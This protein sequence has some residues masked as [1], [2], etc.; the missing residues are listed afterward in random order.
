[1]AHLLK[2]HDKTNK[3]ITSD[4]WIF[5]GA[6]NGGPVGN[7]N[8]QH[9]DYRDFVIDTFKRNLN[10]FAKPVAIHPIEVFSDDFFKLWDNDEVVSDIMRVDIQ[11]GGNISFAYIDGN[12]TYEYAKRDFQNVSKYLDT[13]GFILFDDSSD[14]THF[15]CAELMKE[16]VDDPHFE[17]VIKN[18]N[19]LFK[20]IS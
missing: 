5:E 16:I 15:G 1:M 4:R 10:F 18:P 19:Y 2:K 11:L 9:S 17:L 12:H 20:K 6:E 13:G 8:I 3:I 14:N 7:S